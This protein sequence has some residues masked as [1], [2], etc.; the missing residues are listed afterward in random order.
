VRHVRIPEER[1]SVLIGTG[2]E[3]LDE[4]EEL[5]KVEVD[6]TDDG[7]V[8]IDGT[9]PA[10][11]LEELRAYNIVKAIGR[12]FSPEK[13]LRLLEDNST[14]CVLN[15]NDFTGGSDNAKERLKGRVIGQDGQAREKMEQ[16]TD[17][18]IAVYGK[19]VAIL[20]KVPNVEVAREAATMLLEGRSHATVYDY[21]K[22]NQAKIL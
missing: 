7:E 19:T 6:V 2:G 11:P 8:T 4:I 9:D 22:R 17:T 15:I 13:A 16:D 1:V 3:T 5:L 14:L 10:D 20:G 21:L 12:G 18:E